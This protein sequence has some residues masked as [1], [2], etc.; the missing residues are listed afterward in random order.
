MKKALLIIAGLIWARRH[1]AIVSGQMRQIPFGHTE[2]AG[3][4]S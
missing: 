3:R 2:H 4:E 1:G